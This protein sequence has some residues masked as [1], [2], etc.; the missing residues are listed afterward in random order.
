M[1]TFSA[2]DSTARHRA[3]EAARRRQQYARERYSLEGLT[4][5]SGPL[6]AVPLEEDEDDREQNAEENY[7]EDGEA[8]DDGDSGDEEEYEG[9]ENAIKVPQTYEPFQRA[10]LI[11]NE[12][13]DEMDPLWTD[14]S[15]AVEFRPKPVP[16]PALPGA[17]QMQALRSTAAPL[18]ASTSPT[19]TSTAA[20]RTTP[21][22]TRRTTVAER[23]TTAR[24]PTTT[25]QR[26]MSYLYGQ[27]CQYSLM[28]S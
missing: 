28:W 26:R 25:T 6:R 16:Y 11:P 15:K 21:T 20:P 14:L 7:S 19:S 24:P 22:A 1:Q 17:P 10:R 23:T 2:A 3:A 18:P 8:G 5:T 12:G 13:P 27:Y 9:D 4:T